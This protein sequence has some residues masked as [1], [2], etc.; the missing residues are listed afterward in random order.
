GNTQLYVLNKQLQLL[1]VGVVG[2]LYIGGD[3]LAHGYW[4]KPELTAE[5]FIANPFKPGEKMYRTGDLASWTAQGEIAFLGRTD[6]QVKLRG[7]R[8][9]LGEIESRLV[10]H[11]QVKEAAVAVKAREGQKYLVGYY[12]VRPGAGQLTAGQLAG[13][14][15]GHLPEY[16][17]PAY[18]VRLEALPLTPNGKLDRKA[19]PL[20]EWQAADA[21]QAPST[22][23][24]HKLVDVWAQV[25]KVDRQFIS[26]DK[27]FFKLGGHSLL[28]ATLVARISHELNATVRLTTLFQFPTVAALAAHLSKKGQPK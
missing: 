23:I 6:D 18:L 7:F 10:S 1:P 19:L 3:G 21:Y 26:V 20:P 12:A 28:A 27:S 2:E 8:I 16:M 9:E 5:K 4:N 17:V 25:L 22:P 15:S 13:Y 14:L 24:E 11:P